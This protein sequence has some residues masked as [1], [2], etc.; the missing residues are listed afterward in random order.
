MIFIEV[1]F[2]IKLVNMVH[3]C[4]AYGCSNRYHKD[5]DITFHKFPTIKQRVV[6]KKWIYATKRSNFN[7]GVYARV[8]SVH[9]RSED[10]DTEFARTR[11]R[12]KEGAIP[13]IFKSTKAEEKVPRR[14]LKRVQLSPV[15]LHKCDQCSREFSKGWV[16]KSHT[17]RVHGKKNYKCDQCEYAASHQG[18]LSKHVDKVHGSK[19]HDFSQALVVQSEAGVSHMPQEAEIPPTVPEDMNKHEEVTEREELMQPPLDDSFQEEHSDEVDV[20]AELVGCD[21]TSVLQSEVPEDNSNSIDPPPFKRHKSSH[22][23]RSL[24][25]PESQ[26]HLLDHNYAFSPFIDDIKKR[27]QYLTSVVEKKEK[28][29]CKLRLKISRLKRSNAN[30]HAVIHELRK[31]ELVSKEAA[32]FLGERFSEVDFKLIKGLVSDKNPAYAYSEDIKDFS[33]SLFYYRDDNLIGHTK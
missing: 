21:L 13:T 18:D 16:L 14:V 2:V 33:I 29:E 11:R 19:V 26:S 30:L 20:T 31:A 5:S 28:N 23:G 10:F 24:Q 6:R 7:P 27:C 32:L 12:L 15:K 17:K 9:F 3:T 8:C 25:E 22:E 4:A 1:L